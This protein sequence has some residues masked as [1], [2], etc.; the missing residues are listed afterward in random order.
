MYKKEDLL[1]DIIKIGIKSTDTLLIH[2]SMK[3]IGDVEGG[4]ET[5]L[6]AFIEYMSRGLLIFPTHSW[7][8]INKENPLFDVENEP[9]CVGLLSNLF[10]KR[11]GV[12]RSWHPTHSVAAL[13]KDA[14]EYIMGEE[15][16]TTPCSRKGC[17]GKLYDRKARI[18]FLGCTTKKNTFIHGVEEWYDIK[19]RLAAEPVIFKIKTPRGNILPCT[20]FRHHSPIKDISLN[21]DKIQSPLLQKGISVKGYIGDA[22]SYLCDAQKMSDFTGELLKKN[23]DLFLDDAPV[24]KN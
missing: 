12:L 8:S 5:V 23:P 1:R 18:L 11:P 22:L 20:Q 19:N 4:A 15:K 10:L 21:Y 2:S 9:S 14:A 17:W 7:D 16:S 13:G 24:I 6:D 3:A